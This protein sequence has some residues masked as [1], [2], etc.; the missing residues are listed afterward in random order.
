MSLL[1]IESKATPLRL[2]LSLRRGLYLYVRHEFTEKCPGCGEC[3]DL[4]VTHI[5]SL[6]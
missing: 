4:G 2:V 6:N 3:H 5:L 1:T